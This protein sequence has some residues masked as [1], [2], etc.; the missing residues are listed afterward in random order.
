[1]CDI[2]EMA[3]NLRNATA[4]L[5]R[6]AMEMSPNDLR[7]SLK[8]VESLANVLKD[9]VEE[10]NHMNGLHEFY[11]ARSEHLEERGFDDVE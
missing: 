10:M 5:S 8:L 9:D 3:E 7:T 11:L 4:M 1:M 6:N 2:T